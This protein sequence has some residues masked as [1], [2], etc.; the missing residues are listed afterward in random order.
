MYPSQRHRLIRQVLE[1]ALA[2]KLTVYDGADTVKALAPAALK[3]KIDALKDSAFVK[4]DI[5][6]DYT[7]FNE[8]IFDEDWYYDAVTQQFY[9]K[10][11]AITFVH[12]KPDT[13]SEKGP[14]RNAV[15]VFTVKMR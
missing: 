9:K 5:N 1:P 3:A 2:G 14:V 11:N 8:L 15:A 6:T 7:L 10:V 12:R 4:G 13:D